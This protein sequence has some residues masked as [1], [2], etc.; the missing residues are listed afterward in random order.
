MDG[1]TRGQSPVGRFIE[2]NEATAAALLAAV[3]LKPASK[4]AER[5]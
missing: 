4:A 5:A 1:A 2:M 3:I